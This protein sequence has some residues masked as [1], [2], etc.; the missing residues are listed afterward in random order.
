MRDASPLN[1][2]DHLSE[3]I[4]EATV[5]KRPSFLRITGHLH[6]FEV[7]LAV[8]S[9]G[10]AGWQFVKIDR[11]L[12][13]FVLMWMV[14][15]LAAIW[16]RLKGG[17][18]GFIRGWAIVYLVALSAGDIVASN[19]QLLPWI[20][21]LHPA[22]TEFA[23]RWNRLDFVSRRMF[24]WNMVLACASIYCLPGYFIGWRN[25]NDRIRLGRSE[26]SLVTSVLALLV[27]WIL[28]GI[29]FVWFLVN[30]FTPT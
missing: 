5:W 6:W 10:M 21:S 13:P 14:P 1:T 15:P 25:F 24:S 16:V 17:S 2:D 22:E 29:G 26:F 12:A 20:K 18:R 30:M 27:F 28:P 23:E 8:W 7:I 4:E 19:A 11:Q 9:L 3:W